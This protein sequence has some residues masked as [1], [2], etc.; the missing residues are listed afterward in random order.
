MIVANMKLANGLWIISRVLGVDRVLDYFRQLFL[1][2]FDLFGY[3]KL[4]MGCYLHQGV[5]QLMGVNAVN[6]GFYLVKGQGLPRVDVIAYNTQ[7]D[8]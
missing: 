2:Y 1:R 8:F 3:D 4:G 6:E 7:L 5:C